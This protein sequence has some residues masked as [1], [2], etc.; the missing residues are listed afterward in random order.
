[1]NLKK[2][3]ERKNELK[4]KTESKGEESQ[5]ENWKLPPRSPLHGEAEKESQKENW[6][7]KLLNSFPNG[8][9]IRWISKRE[10]KAF[11]VLSSSFASSYRPLNLKKRIES[12]NVFAH[13]SLIYTGISKRE[14]KAIV[15][16]WVSPRQDLV[17]ISKRELKELS[18]FSLSPFVHECWNFIKENWK[19]KI[20]CFK[21]FWA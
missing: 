6:K 20:R 4:P 12:S 13:T 9:L 8:P 14:L 15:L 3:I 18:R 19:E 17:G 11:P 2:R 21:G 10:L 7:L 5:K 16:E 1:M